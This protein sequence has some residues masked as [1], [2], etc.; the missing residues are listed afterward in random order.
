MKKSL[1]TLSGTF[2]LATLAACSGG[3]DQEA[4]D[5]S[6]GGDGGSSGE[7]VT[8]RL[9]HWYN[10]EQDN[11][12]DVIASFEEDHPNINVESVTPENNDANETMQQIDLA[13]A[14]GDQLD[15]IMVNDA[16]NYAQRVSQGMF[17]PLNSYID[18]AGFNFDEE[19]RVNTAVDGERYA[20]PGKYNMHFVMMNQDKLDENNLELPTEWTWSDFMDY[21][22]QLSEGEGA[23]KMYGTYFHTWV[24][25]V[26]LA[27]FNQPEN[28]NL[29]KDDGTTSNIDSE[30][31]RQSLEIR[32]RGHKDGSAVPYDNTISQELSYRD[33][34]FN[35]SAASILTGSWMISEAG[36]IDGSPSPFNVSF[37][38]YPKAEEGDPVTTPAGADFLSVYSGSKNKDAAF[39]FI[40]WYTTEGIQEQGKYLPAYQDADLQEVVDNLVQAGAAPDKVD[41]ESLI[42]VLE[43]SE[44][45]PLNIP[46]TYIGEVED[47]YMSETDAFLLGEQDLE[48]TIQN[49]DEAA[50]EIIDNNA[51]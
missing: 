15:V 11:W 46:P 14:S 36:G 3:G 2:L 40:R 32:Q 17:E 13:A 28:S 42:N 4:S 47:A 34:F 6:D 19:Y 35:E 12:D 20:L 39:E 37:A 25:Y 27:A 9:H 38:P 24:D 22:D 51:E 43:T 7:E 1:L 8:I 41:T 10:E 45:A 26:K 31:I 33:Q 23:N 21:A 50:Q 5:S 48:T 18:E 16:S 44:A 29:V 49:A 30:K